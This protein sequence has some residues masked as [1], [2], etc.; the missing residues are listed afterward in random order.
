MLRAQN[1]EPQA[2]VVQETRGLFIFMGLAVL[3]GVF[4]GGWTLVF[5]PVRLANS[6]SADYY[7]DH[8]HVYFFPGQRGNSRY[9][10]KIRR[11]FLKGEP[12]KLMADE[13]QLNRWSRNLLPLM[14]G[15]FVGIKDVASLVRSGDLNFRV[16]NNQFQMAQPTWINLGTMGGFA[17][18]QVHGRFKQEGEGF[19]FVPE[20]ATL[21][22]C[23]MPFPE[24]F[25]YWVVLPLFEENPEYKKVARRWADIKAIEVD[26]NV[27]EVTL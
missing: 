16:E 26:A 18:Y 6:L 25:F 12:G 14:N 23:P 8:R 9:W 27:L 2:P 5:K 3:L 17:L 11:Q 1:N 22:S 13:E 19:A 4:I 20:R 7:N 24:L 15:H 21:G 10:A